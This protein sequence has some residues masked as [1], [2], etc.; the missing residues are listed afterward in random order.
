MLEADDEV[1]MALVATGDPKLVAVVVVQ[2]GDA[3]DN[4]LPPP[5][6]S[7]RRLHFLVLFWCLSVLVFWSDCLFPSLQLV[8]ISI[9]W[10]CSLEAPRVSSGMCIQILV[11]TF[12]PLPTYILI[13]Y[14]GRV[15]SSSMEVWW[16][17]RLPEQ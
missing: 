3:R 7:L 16:R 2:E 9:L 4:L 10:A 15:L 8:W 5:P 17:L 14:L 13:G 11:Q 12:T 1:M 6:A